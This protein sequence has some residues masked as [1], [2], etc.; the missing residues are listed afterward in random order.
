MACVAEVV[1]VDHERELLHR[2]ACALEVAARD[3]CARCCLA[4][5]PGSI[6]H[7]ATA[8]A[9]AVGVVAG[10]V[11]DVAPGR[12]GHVYRI[13]ERVHIFVAFHRSEVQEVHLWA[14]IHDLARANER[15][16]VEPLRLLV[17]Q[18]PI[19]LPFLR[20]TPFAALT[21]L[22]TKVVVAG[23]HPR[24]RL[25]DD[26]D[27]LAAAMWRSGVEQLAVAIIRLYDR[28]GGQRGASQL[29]RVPISVGWVYGW[30]VPILRVANVFRV[31]PPEA[32]CSSSQQVPESS[33]A[34][35]AER[36]PGE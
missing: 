15:A 16:V 10:V 2:V 24:D 17:A 33:R 14:R 13:C 20:H 18:S 1:G 22:A 5:P 21:A 6:P 34:H 36:D 30:G 27:V 9:A 8:V 4:A 28:A 25:A 31:L 3:D 35:F 19:H 11:A 7:R 12:A 32:R 26:G 29:G 23:H